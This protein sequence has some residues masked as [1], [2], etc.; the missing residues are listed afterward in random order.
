[1]RAWLL[2]S[3]AFVSL[4]AA[5]GPFEK[6][7]GTPASVTIE[8]PVEVPLY[9]NMDGEPFPCVQVQIADHNFLFELVTSTS[10]HV[11][12]PD[13]AKAA[14]LKAKSLNK[15]LVNTKGTDR[16]DKVGGTFEG[17]RLDEIKIGAVTLSDVLVL[18]KPP[19]DPDAG[20]PASDTA[21]DGELSLPA[22]EQLGWA[23]LPSKGVVRFVPAADAPGLLTIT[24]GAAYGYT[25]RESDVVKF[26]KAKVYGYPRPIRIA[27]T[28]A[29]RESPLTRISVDWYYGYIHPA[30]VA[31]TATVRTEGDQRTV[32]TTAQIAGVTATATLE[33]QPKYEYYEGVVE[34]Q[35]TAAL[36]ADVLSLFDIAADPVNHRIT[37]APTTSQTRADPTDW[38]I[39][40]AE[41]GL[42]KP[43]P[44][45]GEEPPKEETEEW[46]P[47]PAVLGKLAKLHDRRGEYDK[48]V[49]YWKRLTEQEARDCAGWHGLG[50]QQIRA[51]DLEGAVNSLTQ[52]ATLYH[53]WWDLPVEE[54]QEISTTLAK[55][56]PEE[57]K[58]AEHYQQP[59]TCYT[60]ESDLASAQYLRNDY[61]T[62]AQLA[63]RADLDSK[64]TTAAGNAALASGDLTAAS[65]AY[66][67]S[68]VISRQ[69]A[70]KP[71][72]G[73]GIVYSQ[74]GD[75]GTAR[76]QIE[77]YLA[78]WPADPEALQVWLDVIRT[79]EGGPAALDAIRRHAETFHDYDAPCFA[80]YREAKR[81]GSSADLQRAAEL[82]AANVRWNQ[83]TGGRWDY[84]TYARYLIDAGDLPEAEKYVAMAEKSWANDPDTW[85]AKAEL[86]AA[87]GNAGEADAA[88]QTAVRVDPL[89][90]VGALVKAGKF[91]PTVAAPAPEPTTPP[92][93]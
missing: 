68:L 15:K 9:T 86:A 88:L 81:A 75:P 21:F 14:G 1:M 60:A 19:G 82:I 4:P 38:L 61:A 49:G 34:S 91:G 85:F 25:S 6:F 26:G 3:V 73:L 40:E 11:V 30:Y 8:G 12:S 37:F 90:P 76:E 89:S 16:K 79:S 41:K 74:G 53:T 2:V 57:K 80:Y 20:A 5:G 45:E 33:V 70:M 17:G 28:V 32:I 47:D 93:K 31:E 7:V 29:D 36:G 44:K 18:T 56:E 58:A 46:K 92:T 50:A 66:R 51:G 72:L 24:G 62:V 77:R 35:S 78:E 84:G 22:L 63:T 48:A 23:I 69:T 27:A 10:M 65:A 83:G 42:V 64:L 43:V 54:R 87:K 71:R 52:A 13:V 59:A 39:A 55:L 67:R